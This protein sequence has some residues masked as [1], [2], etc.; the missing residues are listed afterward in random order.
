MNTLLPEFLCGVKPG[1]FPCH[2]LDRRIILFE[3]L[4]DEL[5]PDLRVREWKVRNGFP[6]NQG[7]VLKVR[8]WEGKKYSYWTKHP[9]RV[10]WTASESVFAATDTAMVF[11][12]FRRYKLWSDREAE[13]RTVNRELFDFRRPVIHPILYRSHDP[14]VAKP[15]G[16]VL[17]LFDQIG[18]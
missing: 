7:I 1:D 14:H 8:Y 5:L 4:P 9:K 6:Q 17:V 13:K 18:A 15:T 12:D 10:V 11:P 3:F 16:E 2:H